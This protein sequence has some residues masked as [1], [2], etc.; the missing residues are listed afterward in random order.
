MGLK[1][2]A[3]GAR[4]GLETH[5]VSQRPQNGGWTGVAVRSIPV[6]SYAS[7]A[8]VYRLILSFA[9]SARRK[10]THN[11]GPSSLWLC[12]R[13]HAIRLTV[14]CV[15]SFGEGGGGV[16]LPWRVRGETE[17]VL[18]Y[19]CSGNTVAARGTGRIP[20][21]GLREGQRTSSL[22][23]R[24]EVAGCSPQLDSGGHV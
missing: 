19:I 13:G 4:G 5:V 9:S 3:R 12:A 2:Q 22:S 23:H 18:P 21:L 15:P 24:R 6:I 8:R 14:S 16:T 7:S 11:T 10:Q 1:K 17:L 20:S